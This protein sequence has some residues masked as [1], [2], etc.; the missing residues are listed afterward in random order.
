MTP[1]F[2]IERWL[3]CQRKFEI[4]K[5]PLSPNRVRSPKQNHYMLYKVVFSPDHIPLEIATRRIFDP[6]LHFREIRLVVKENYFLHFL[7]IAVRGGLLDPCRRPQVR[8]SSQ[9][10]D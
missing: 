3:A 1:H 9:T 2:G 6:M 10:L 7:S 5:K 8:P 4:G